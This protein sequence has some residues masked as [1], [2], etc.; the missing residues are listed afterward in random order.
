[1][2]FSRPEI[3]VLRIAAMTDKPDHVTPA[4]LPLAHLTLTD[5][6]TPEERAADERKE[7]ARRKGRG[8]KDWWKEESQPPRSS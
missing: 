2:A 6:R 8:R 1:V 7:R 5:P 4:A 3:A